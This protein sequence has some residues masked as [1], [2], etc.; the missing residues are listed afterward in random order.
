MD[1]C[2]CSGFLASGRA[3]R[4]WC[5]DVVVLTTRTTAKCAQRQFGAFLL[6][7]GEGHKPVAIVH[8][9]RVLG[10]G[11]K[12]PYHHWLGLKRF[13]ALRSIAL[14][15]GVIDVHYHVHGDDLDPS[16]SDD[17]SWLVVLTRFGQTVR[18]RTRG[19][20]VVK[21]LAESLLS[22]FSSTHAMFKHDLGIGNTG[23]SY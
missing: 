1:L 21:L 19:E 18:A 15:E 16:G 12:Q 23:I 9:I 11:R 20:L 17:G 10:G 22:R 2:C 7:I 4:N 3:R 5:C 14:H 6:E 8:D 13:E